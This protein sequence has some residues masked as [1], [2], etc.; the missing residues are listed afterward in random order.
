V[1]LLLLLLPPLLTCVR[2]AELPHQHWPLEA[3]APAA[4]APGGEVAKG[5]RHALEQTR[6]LQGVMQQCSSSAAAA[7]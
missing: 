7:K 1:L 6:G 2:C 5:V 3:L 4:V